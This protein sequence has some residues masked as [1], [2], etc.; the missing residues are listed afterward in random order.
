MQAYPSFSQGFSSRDIL[1][2]PLAYVL[3]SLSS[4]KNTNLTTRTR[5]KLWLLIYVSVQGLGSLFSK[6]VLTESTIHKELA[7]SLCFPTPPWDPQDPFL[8]GTWAETLKARSI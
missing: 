1:S 7:L 5:L 2:D 3:T 8:P 4:L 6:A